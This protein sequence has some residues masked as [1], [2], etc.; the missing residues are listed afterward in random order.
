MGKGEGKDVADVEI[1]TKEFITPTELE[2]ERKKTAHEFYDFLH[3]KRQTWSSE[4][5]QKRSKKVDA[6]KTGHQQ[7][8]DFVDKLI[9]FGG[10]AA[11][12][13]ELLEIL[14]KANESRS[15]SGINHFVVCLDESGSMEGSPWQALIH[16]FR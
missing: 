2:N 9:N 1:A 11:M 13:Q 4:Q 10:D 15:A 16:A 6:A 3:N 7:G 5:S 12:R 14:A 8:Q